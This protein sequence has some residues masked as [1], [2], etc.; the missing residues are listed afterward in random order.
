VYRSI[1]SAGTTFQSG[2]H[3]I[4]EVGDPRFWGVPTTKWF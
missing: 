4:W 1:S 3:H 2:L